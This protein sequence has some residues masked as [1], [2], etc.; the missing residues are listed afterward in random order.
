MRTRILV[1]IIL[2]FGA[3]HQRALSHTAQG[4][5][6]AAPVS[7]APTR[8]VVV[9]VSSPRSD[10]IPSA[11]TADQLGKLL[12]PREKEV[13]SEIV[14]RKPIVETYIQRTKKDET[15]GLATTHDFYFLGQADFTNHVRLLPIVHHSKTGNFLWSFEPSGFLS[16]AF[17]DFGGFI[18]ANYQ[19]DYRGREF[20]GEVRCDVVDVT[21]KKHKHGRFFVGRIWVED[22]EFTI[23]RFNGIFTLE[24]SLSPT[25]ME[26]HWFRFDSWRTNVRPGLWMPS[27][28]FCQEISKEKDFIVPEFKSQTRFWGYGQT[29]NAQ[30][31]EFSR[32][33]LETDSV[34]DESANKDNSPL[35][36]QRAF[37]HEAE[38]NVLELLQRESLVSP[39]GSV[40]KILGTIINNIVVANNLEF[41]MGLHYRVM[42]TA[43]L[44][45][46]SIENTIVI[47]RGLLDVVP[48]EATL[49]ALLSQEVADALLSKPYQSRYAFSDLTRMDVTEIMKR[50]SFRDTKQ[51][52]ET[53]QAK[54]FELL[55]KSPY[56]GKLATAGLFLAE[57]SRQSKDLSQLISPRMGNRNWLADQIR[58]SAPKLEPANKTQLAALPIGARIRMDA[59]TNQ[60]VFMKTANVPL[61][62]AG[63][64]LPLEIAPFRPY[65]TRFQQTVSSPPSVDP[66][67]M[68]P[69]PVPDIHSD[70]STEA[71]SSRGYP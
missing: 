19:L 2:L 5:E 46:F 33:L 61:V 60:I 63:E 7:S 26:S 53:I 20:L 59:W 58:T 23:I 12:F 48:D 47:T 69:V 37:N 17:P 1:V 8:F 18:A 38:R 56:A 43:N 32:M 4:G 54:S 10:A 52:A 62:S 13:Q 14:R 16:M 11:L 25:L 31:E 22:Q 41:P 55:Q 67:D 70:K 65:L 21:P 28:I 57:L 29:A 71:S 50:L 15:L 51:E 39:T 42:L 64:K 3:S 9:P 30:Q 36:A 49:A 68:P 34:A 35:E 40:E 24:H 66:N 44:D 6:A 45:L 27:Y